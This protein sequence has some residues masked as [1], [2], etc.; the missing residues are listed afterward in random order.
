MFTWMNLK[1]VRRVL[2]FYIINCVKLKRCILVLI[3]IN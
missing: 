3:Y 1:A 2:G